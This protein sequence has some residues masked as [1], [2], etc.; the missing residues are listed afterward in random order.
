M[1]GKDNKQ[2]KLSES[3]KPPEV[4]QSKNVYPRSVSQSPLEPLLLLGLLRSLFTAQDAEALEDY[5]SI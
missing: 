1:N 5:K 4:K 2:H 3:E